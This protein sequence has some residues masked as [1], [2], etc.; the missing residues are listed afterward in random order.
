MLLQMY[1]MGLLMHKLDAARLQPPPREDSTAAICARQ[2]SSTDNIPYLMAEEH[3]S[4]AVNST[5]FAGVKPPSDKGIPV[6][7]P[8]YKSSK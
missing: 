5:L 3:I 2:A 6:V 4:Q 7:P 8:L 1:R